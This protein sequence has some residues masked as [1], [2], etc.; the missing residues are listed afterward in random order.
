MK[1]GSAAP[2]ELAAHAFV[3]QGA[4]PVLH[5]ATSPLHQTSHSCGTT[6]RDIAARTWW[7]GPTFVS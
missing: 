5:L 7:P 1:Q 4:S 3:T 6:E 2:S